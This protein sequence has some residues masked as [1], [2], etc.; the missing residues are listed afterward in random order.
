MHFLCN[1]LMHFFYCLVLGNNLETSLTEVA[2][3]SSKEKLILRFKSYFNSF[4][5]VKL[6][7]QPYLVTP[8]RNSCDVV[9]QISQFTEHLQATASN[10]G[11]FK[12]L[13]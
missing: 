10:R 2:Y 3:F 6:E 8:L 1:L 11:G 12:H 9:R 13:T 4:I 5:A 7:V